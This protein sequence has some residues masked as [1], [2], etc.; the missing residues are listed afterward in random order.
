MVGNYKEY[1]ETKNSF[2][3]NF[4]TLVYEDFDRHYKTWLSV[5]QRIAEV[6]AL[7]CL[8]KASATIGGI[9]AEK[10]ICIGLAHI[11]FIC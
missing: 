8:A 9:Y 2:V 11:C 6:D 7:L 5:T 3:K 1:L 4:A 10:D